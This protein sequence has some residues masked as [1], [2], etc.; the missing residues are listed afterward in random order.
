[1]CAVSHDGYKAYGEANGPLSSDFYSLCILGSCSFIT[2]ASL[3]NNLILL[4]FIFQ[5]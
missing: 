2:M 5:F 1:M 4:R 3:S